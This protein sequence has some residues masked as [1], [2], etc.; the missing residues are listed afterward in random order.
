MISYDLPLPAAR[1]PRLGETRARRF[2]RPF[3]DLPGPVRC[4]GRR[5]NR[6][7]C[8]GNCRPKAG[9]GF[10]YFSGTTEKIPRLARMAPLGTQAKKPLSALEIGVDRLGHVFDR[11]GSRMLRS[12]D[13]KSRRRLDLELVDGA[14]AD[15]FDAIEHLLI[16]EAGVESLFR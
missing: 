4:R 12:I 14:L 15:A 11:Q 16:R 1:A 2:A 5:M 10:P 7:A 13:E 6:R 8:E 9:G 3:R